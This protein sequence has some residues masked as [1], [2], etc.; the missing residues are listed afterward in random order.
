MKDLKANWRTHL[1]GSG[2]GAQYSGQAQP[3]VHEGVIYLST[4]ANDVFAISVET[5]ATLWDYRANLDPANKSVCCSWTNRG[6]AAGE[7]KI[8]EGQLESLRRFKDDVNEVR[9][10]TECGI[11]VRNYN[12]VKPGDQIE[13]YERTEIARKVG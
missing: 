7:G 11:G 9:A 4:G 13:C 10:G 12:D 5:G 2:V 3:I 6:V 8:F 1:N